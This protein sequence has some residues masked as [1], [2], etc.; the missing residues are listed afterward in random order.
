[1]KP[2]DL[3]HKE[4]H[5]DFISPSISYTWTTAICRRG[6]K[7]KDWFPKTVGLLYPVQAH[8]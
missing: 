7:Y 2:Y 8:K 1:M 5:T 6:Y 4:N 3:K